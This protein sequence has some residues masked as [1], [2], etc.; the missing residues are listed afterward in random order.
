MS[1]AEIKP[2]GEILQ[3]L[4]KADQEAYERINRNT[5]ALAGS[6]NANF[7]FL[8]RALAEMGAN[9]G[10]LNR[11]VLTEALPTYLENLAASKRS[12]S[13][14]IMIAVGGI[15]VSAIVT[16]GVAVWQGVGSTTAG[17]LAEKQYR[18]T[19]E[20]LAKQLAESRRASELLTNM[21][22]EARTANEH[23][24]KMINE[25]KSQMQLLLNEVRDAQL[26]H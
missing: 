26:E 17:A 19:S 18:E 21:L 20:S 25:Q 24:T 10:E 3:P 6:A 12:E 2:I 23:A 16:L 8:S 7:E 14:S 11:A 4:I 1:R 13:R 9:V 15:V 22:E 5:V